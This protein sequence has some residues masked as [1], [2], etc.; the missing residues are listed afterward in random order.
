L[1]FLFFVLVG[2]KKTLGSEYH[3]SGSLHVREITTRLR[4]VNSRQTTTNCK[5]FLFE[6]LLQ[7]KQQQTQQTHKQ[8]V[9]VYLMAKDLK[10]PTQSGNLFENAHKQHI[11]SSLGDESVPK[12]RSNRSRIIFRLEG[13]EYN[14]GSA[15]QC[16]ANSWI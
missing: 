15:S 11:S 1:L 14:L 10:V 3:T 16:Y 8:Y 2:Q 9:V 4:V 13:N 5:L 12:L 7:K 6:N